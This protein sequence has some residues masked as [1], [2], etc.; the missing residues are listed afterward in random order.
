MG[1]EAVG[2]G[3]LG[4]RN[5]MGMNKVIHGGVP[6]SGDLWNFYRF[7]MCLVRIIHY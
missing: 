1:V 3:N 6:V 2:M 4:V 5:R 7:T